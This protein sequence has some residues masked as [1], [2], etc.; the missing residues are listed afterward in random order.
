MTVL[1]AAQTAAQNS[2]AFRVQ[3]G[4]TVGISAFGLTDAEQVTLQRMNGDGTWSNITGDAG[5]LT[6]SVDQIRVVASG[7]YRAVKPI[8]VALSGVDID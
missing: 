5:A 7:T 8:T 4:E 1:I 2:P 6:V 3:R